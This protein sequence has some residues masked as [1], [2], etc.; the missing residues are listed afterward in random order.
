MSAN[1]W[2][3]PIRVLLVEDEPLWQEGIRSLLESN[4]R[5]HLVGVAEDFESVL[6]YFQIF[7]PQMVLLD[8]KIRGEQDGL[9]VGA[10]LMEQGVPPEH[11]VLISSSSPS[12]IPRH[13][14][15]H[16]PKS[17]LSGDLLPL[18]ESVTGSVTRRSH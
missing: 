17:R 2:E 16:V 18:L 4:G 10:W 6:N 13:P 12:S 7:H 15:L 9:A 8:W 1:T 3:L 14:F 5:Y 11:I